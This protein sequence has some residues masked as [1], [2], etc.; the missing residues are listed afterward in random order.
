M[1]LAESSLFL[2]R[3]KYVTADRI[4]L[5]HDEVR[6]HHLVPCELDRRII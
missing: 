5:A 2:R 1:L 3:M 6:P 4:I